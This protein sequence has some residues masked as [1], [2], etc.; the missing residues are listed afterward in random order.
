MKKI[1]TAVAAATVAFGV[2]AGAALAADW[3]KITIAT[4]GAYAPWNFTDSNGNLVGFEIDLAQDLCKRMGAEC[5]II[6]TAWDGIIPSLQGGKFDAIMAGMSITEKRKQV[7]SF[8][9]A[10]A[11]TPA[12]LAVLKDSPLLKADLVDMKAN[13]DSIEPAEKDAIEKMKA[14]LKGKTVG[15][16]VST[17]HANFLEEFFSGTVDIKSYDTQENLDLDLLAGRVDA[18]LA[19]LSY[20]KPALDGDLGQKATVIG[21]EFTGGPFGSGVG[22]G[23]RQQDADLNEK[24][25]AAIGQACADGTIRKL[26]MQWFGFDAAACE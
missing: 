9:A 15:V 7:I 5:S 2:S 20:W 21:T 24:F 16:Q 4:E 11:A 8:S 22:V 25:T 1:A 6:G 18:A 26:A 3:S 23:I 13:L 19:S 14:A 17:T 10:Y 12:K